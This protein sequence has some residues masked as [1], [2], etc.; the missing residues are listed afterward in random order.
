MK[1]LNRFSQ[2]FMAE[3]AISRE[4][5]EVRLQDA[6]N[7]DNNIDRKFSDVR[8]KLENLMLIEQKIAR[9]QSMVVPAPPVQPPNND[10]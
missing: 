3:L 4:K 8:D 2:I 7:K 10:E 1:D 5:A 9:W 6:I